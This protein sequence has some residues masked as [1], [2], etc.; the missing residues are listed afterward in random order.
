MGARSF[1]F[2]FIPLRFVALG[3]SAFLLIVGILSAAGAFVLFPEFP[4]SEV[5]QK[6][7]V[8]IAGVFYAFVALSSIVGLA[9]IVTRTPPVLQLY[10]T[11][12]A[13]CT[14]PEL[15]IDILYLWAYFSTSP[16]T[17]LNDCEAKNGETRDCTLQEKGWAGPAVVVLSVIGMLIVQ[18]LTTY[19][20]HAYA[21]KLSQEYAWTS[22]AP[23]ENT[24]SGSNSPSPST[25][26]KS[27]SNS[28]SN[29]DTNSPYTSE[30]KHLL[31]DSSSAS[32]GQREST[33]SFHLNHLQQHL[34]SP[35]HLHLHRHQKTDSN[36]SNGSEG[37]VQGQGQGRVSGDV[38]RDRESA[39]SSFAF[40][41]YENVS[42]GLHHDVDID[43][44]QHQDQS[45]HGRISSEETLLS[46][47]HSRTHGLTATKEGAMKE[48]E[49]EDAGDSEED[50]DMGGDRP[51]ESLSFP[52]NNNN[53]ERDLNRMSSYES[54]A[55]PYYRSS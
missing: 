49:V 39:G 22:V 27:N 23:V 24:E 43:L 18:P 45:P 8:V 52:R 19:A 4:N 1:C 32:A 17:V 5:G 29:S 15:L 48:G 3:M 9:A 40:V 50:S 33:F 12:L 16:S 51:F 25:Y 34:P 31:D 41:G 53:K 36:G 54:Y 44:E 11:S 55:D 38:N 6:A 13:W 28:K 30:T 35:P 46:N 10:S 37:S 7:V 26:T 14:V 42:P 21:S 20:L 47:P 2:A